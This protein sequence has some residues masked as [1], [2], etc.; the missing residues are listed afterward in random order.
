MYP[1]LPK[2]PNAAS[3]KQI[4]Q[5]WTTELKQYPLP[6][7]LTSWVDDETGI[8]AQ[9]GGFAAPNV[10]ILTPTSKHPFNQNI[11]VNWFKA[12]CQFVKNHHMGGIYYNVVPLYSGTLPTVPKPATPFWI[13]P[14]SQAAI[15]ACFNG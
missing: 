9:S 13:Q 2:L 12:A 6:G 11:Q 1:Y 3:V 8:P 5:A 10:P 15:R 4:V 7:K 14:K